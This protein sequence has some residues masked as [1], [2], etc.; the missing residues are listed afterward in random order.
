MSTITESQG[1]STIGRSLRETRIAAGYSLEQVAAALGIRVSYLEALEGGGLGRILGPAYV[2]SM[3]VRCAI[4]LGLDPEEF[5]LCVLR[6]GGAPANGGPP[7]QARPAAQPLP[8]VQPLPQVQPM[9]AAQPSPSAQPRPV[10][11]STPVS[12]RRSSRAP[13]TGRRVVGTPPDLVRQRPRALRVVTVSVLLLI[14]VAVGVFGALELGLF[15]LPGA[16][17]SSTVGQSGTLVAAASA[18]QTEYTGPPATAGVPEVTATTVPVATT[19]TLAARDE[20]DLVGDS[21]LLRGESQPAAASRAGGFTL[22]IA[23]S[24]E[25]WVEVR[26]VESGQA[27]HMGAIAKGA[28]V[29]L[30]VEGPVNVVAGRPEVLSAKIDGRAVETP[31][32]FRWMVT[33]AGVEA[34]S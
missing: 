9:P 17:D 21:R 11:P 2:E 3:I 5:L 10:T 32:A 26:D 31:N 7:A 15:S 34:R 12:S 20:T 1:L 25:A 33:A 18:T 19:T 6:N 29:T 14:L 8:P 4:Y 28:S 24:D 22:K 27:L 23:A 30:E 13:R 16:I